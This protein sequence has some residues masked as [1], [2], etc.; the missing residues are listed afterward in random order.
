MGVELVRADNDY[1]VNNFGWATFLALAKGYGWK[2]Q[3]T[4]KP[5]Y[6]SDEYGTWDSMDYSSNGVQEVTASDALD[7]SIALRKAINECKED[8]IESCREK[9][10]ELVHFCQQGGFNIY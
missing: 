1:Y 10:V 4:N 8:F 9:L 2:S 7:L 5:F 3:G 6:W